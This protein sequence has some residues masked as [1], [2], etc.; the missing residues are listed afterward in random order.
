MMGSGKTV[1]GKK[2]A[3]LLRQ[4]FVDLDKRLEAHTGYKIR[5]LFEKKGEAYFRDEE[6]RLLRESVKGGPRVVA[7]GGGVVLRPENVRF[8]RETGKVIFLKT[9]LEIIRSR[10]QGKHDRPLLQTEDPQE[11]L[12]KIFAHR[13]ALYHQAADLEVDTDG[14]GAEAVAKKIFTSLRAPQSGARQSQ[15]LPR[16]PKNA[17]GSP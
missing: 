1:T 5:E 3:A 4:E 2:L 11:A 10:L 15:R 7:T 9:S 13:T 6:S 12:R 16:P 8:M 14:L 17:A